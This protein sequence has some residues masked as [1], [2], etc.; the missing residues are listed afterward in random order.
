[1]NALEMLGAGSIGLFVKDGRPR[2][3]SRD[4]ARNFRK[5]HFHVI[6]D[7]E[8]KIFGVAPESFNQ[9]NFG[10][11]EYLD[12]K[13]EL[14][15]SYDMTFEGFSLLA[16]GFTGIKAME[17]K[18][19]Y[20]QAFSAMMDI[21]AGEKPVVSLEEAKTRTQR[22]AVGNIYFLPVECVTNASY[23]SECDIDASFLS[24]IRKSYAGR[25][26]SSRQ[27]YGE[28][29]TWAEAN[30]YQPITQTALGRRFA[31]SGFISSHTAKLRGWR[32]PANLD[33]EV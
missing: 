13:G 17:W 21:I 5:N 1:M 31:N 22:L 33:K 10:L 28:Y 26:V 27:L 18:V 15:K 12:A 30:N 2:T 23:P 6:R 4:V 19:K 29:L 7:I 9:S 11:V 25:W 16:M 3:N 14:R 24:E 8:S 20:I 32:I